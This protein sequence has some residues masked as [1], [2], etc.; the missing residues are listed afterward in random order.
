MKPPLPGRRYHARVVDLPRPQFARRI[1][2]M[3]AE[4]LLA[5]EGEPALMRGVGL[6]DMVAFSVA[7]S[8]ELAGLERIGGPLAGGWDETGDALRWRKP[9]A[10]RSRAAMLRLRHRVVRG[11]RDYFDRQGFLEVET[12][13]LATAPNPEPTFRPVRADG[14]YLITSPEFHLK[15]LLVGGFEKIYRLGPVFRGGEAGPLHNPEFTLL[16]WNRAHAGLEEMAAD[17]EELLR[18]LAPLAAQPPAGEEH[19]EGGMAP[20]NPGLAPALAALP[21]A[22]ATVADL[23]ASHLG[24]ELGGAADGAGLRAAALAAGVDGAGALPDDF[25]GAF[26]SLWD[27]IEPRLPP[28]PLLVVDWPVPLASLARLKEG[29]PPVA[30]RMELLVGGMELAKGFA[31]LTDPAEQRRRFEADL[32]ARAAR[33]LAAPPL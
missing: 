25:E 33:G 18:E 26:H 4:R 21:F 23:F 32:A 3:L 9:A 13:A 5:L 31:E 11:V 10:A 30:E 17:L 15:R 6:G 8:G 24:M 29:S 7:A 27:R 19:T 22:R 2:L 20:G 14:G 12:P 16:E 28:E 1:C